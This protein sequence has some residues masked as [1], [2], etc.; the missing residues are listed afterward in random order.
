M[1]DKN[2]NLEVEVKPKYKFKSAIQSKDITNEMVSRI[3][4]LQIFLEDNEFKKS[5]L[6]RNYRPF[7]K[8]LYIKIFVGEYFYIAIRKD[9]AIE[10]V[11]LPTITDE[12]LVELNKIESSLLAD[13]EFNEIERKRKK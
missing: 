4:I 1:T 8:E 9:G 5:E 12:E 6:S 10:K 7:Y 2:I 11:V 13:I 3:R